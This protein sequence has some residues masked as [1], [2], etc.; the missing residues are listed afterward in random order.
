VDAAPGQP[1]SG[2][3]EGTTSIEDQNGTAVTSV[4]VPLKG[5][6]TVTVLVMP[7]AAGLTLGQTARLTLRTSVAPPTNRSHDDFVDLKIDAAESAPA[8]HKVIFTE[9]VTLPPEDANSAKTN[10]TY[11][12]KFGVL[13]TGAPT[14]AK[15]RV[16]VSLT[17]N[18]SEGWKATVNDLTSATTSPTGQPGVFVRE[19]ELTDDQEQQVSV[20]IRTPTNTSGSTRTASFNVEVESV[21]AALVPSIM[22]THPGTFTVTVLGTGFSNT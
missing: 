19:I 3:W 15:F 7:P 14:K 11:T 20:I 8:P 9:K 16:V 12:W 17:A 2:N 10:S 5:T 6:K 22:A 4:Q 21:D 1:L 13:Y 18:M